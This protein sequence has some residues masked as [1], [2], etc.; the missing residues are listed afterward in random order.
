MGWGEL[1]SPPAN[2]SR[3]A[4]R[5][6]Q[7]T[8]SRRAWRSATCRYA[9][10]QADPALEAFAK[11][12]DAS[13][14]AGWLVDWLSAA[15]TATVV[16]RERGRLREMS[17]LAQEVSL[18][19]EESW[20]S[21][22]RTC[23]EPLAGI[24][25]D[26]LGQLPEAKARQRHAPEELPAVGDSPDAVRAMGD[27]VHVLSREGKSD[28]ALRV[29]R[30]GETLADAN[31]RLRTFWTIWFWTV[32]A[33]IKVAAADRCEQVGGDGR[34]PEDWG[35]PAAERFRRLASPATRPAAA[36]SSIAERRCP[37][38]AGKARTNGSPAS[39]SAS[40]ISSPPPISRWAGVSATAP[41]SRLRRSSSPRWAPRSTDSR[42]KSCS[43]PCRPTCRPSP[44]GSEPRRWS[45]TSVRLRGQC[46][47]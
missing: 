12:R 6:G 32:R 36:S 35:T 45:A 27:S 15:A 20:S 39:A 26:S 44:T 10:A 37:P 13:L 23:G 34:S 41:I 24:A 42:P 46:S 33:E 25:L 2:A 18:R 11:A 47:P 28:E 21:L 14:A 31:P 8:R 4:L 9:T 22:L 40:S 19:G 1:C 5:R 16:L 17:A 29:L 38:A 7:G 43:T 3:R 30:Q